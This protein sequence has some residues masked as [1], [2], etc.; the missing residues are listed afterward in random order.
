MGRKVFVSYKF[1]DSDVEEL[2]GVT[3]PTWPSDYVEYI[4]SKILSRGDV[5]KGEKQDEE[6][7]HLSDISIW[8]HLKR[9]IFDSTVTIVLIS[10]N[11]KEPLKRERSQ[12]IPWE[13]SYSI[14]EEARNDRTSH[15]NAILAVVL[16]NK[17]GHYS[18]FNKNDAFRILK[19]NIDN[20]YIYV[21]NW[22]IFLKYPHGC[23]ALAEESKGKTPSYKIDVNL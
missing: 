22:D 21:T 13:I 18:Y 17:A 3:Q 19:N 5:Y 7:S 11:M 10:P 14:R 8:E 20:G 16:P 4:E 6:I 2:Y 9:K 1:Q 23:I 12:W 15:R